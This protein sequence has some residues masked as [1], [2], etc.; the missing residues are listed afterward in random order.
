MKMKH[1]INGIK[2]RKKYKPMEEKDT[3]QAP[4]MTLMD[5][6]FLVESLLR[7]YQHAAR[8]ER[9]N[10][11]DPYRGQGRVL[12]LLNLQPEISQ[13]DLA[14]LLDMRNQSLGELLA[15]LERN[16]YV[17]RTPS[18]SDRRV[19][20][21]HLTDE[22]K[23][24]AK[25]MEEQLQGVK[26]PFDSLSEEEQETLLAL[27]G[28]VSDALE[29]RMGAIPD[30][31]RGPRFGGFD[32]SDMRGMRMG[33]MRELHRR[34]VHTPPSPHRHGFDCERPME[35]CG[36][37]PPRGPQDAPPFGRGWED[38]GYTDRDE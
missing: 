33:V 19:L 4:K 20:N 36:A 11:A 5:Q 29:A 34:V 1:D 12:A 24:A 30:D 13:R 8:R 6:F 27:L 21:V 23:K 9:G 2:E 38:P 3:T 17:E 28:K 16:G 31:E 7:R 35:P 22:G 37:R 25:R 15:K 26:D 10:M 32:P 18:E 14:Y